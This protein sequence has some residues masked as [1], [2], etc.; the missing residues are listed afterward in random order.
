MNENGPEPRS[1]Q[2]PPRLSTRIILT[3]CKIRIDLNV[4]AANTP[5]MISI[6]CKAGRVFLM[7]AVSMMPQAKIGRNDYRENALH[8]I[9]NV[10][11][12]KLI[13]IFLCVSQ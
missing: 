11:I 3:I 6:A 13:E 9:S 10:L 7:V 5:L 12:S 1:F 4:D 2:V 8:F